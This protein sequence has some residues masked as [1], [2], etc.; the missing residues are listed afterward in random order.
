VRRVSKWQSVVDSKTDF[1]GNAYE[2]MSDGHA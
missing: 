1:M 2:S